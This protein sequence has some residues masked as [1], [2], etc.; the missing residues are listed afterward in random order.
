MDSILW[1]KIRRKIPKKKT[2]QK[3]LFEYFIK[4]SKLYKKTLTK[5]YKKTLI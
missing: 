5:L 1:P 2:R 3:A 4:I